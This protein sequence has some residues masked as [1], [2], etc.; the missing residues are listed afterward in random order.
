MLSTESRAETLQKFERISDQ[1]IGL[2]H[3]LCPATYKCFDL[4][5]EERQSVASGISGL[6]NEGTQVALSLHFKCTPTRHK[7]GFKD[8]SK[9]VIQFQIFKDLSSNPIFS[10]TFEIP[11]KSR[12]EQK[13]KNIKQIQDLPQLVLQ[14]PE[15]SFGQRITITTLP[16]I[17]LQ[18]LGIKFEETNPLL[19]L[20][21]K[22]KHEFFVQ[23]PSYVKSKVEENRRNTKNNKMVANVVIVDR[24]LEPQ[25]LTLTFSFIDRETQ[26]VLHEE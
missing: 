3:Q 11:F 1:Y 25:T 26:S 2:L 18:S 23:C 19:I 9:I 21:D 8:K 4:R 10:D 17:N 24:F 15:A 22:Q 20:E 12:K 5:E 14:P 6:K 7:C 13:L 16:S